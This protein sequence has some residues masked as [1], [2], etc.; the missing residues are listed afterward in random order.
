MQKR[1]L[2]SRTRS[3]VDNSDAMSEAMSDASD[4]SDLSDAS[5]FRDRVMSTA[6]VAVARWLLDLLWLCLDLARRSPPA[7]VAPRP[8]SLA[9]CPSSPRPPSLVVRPPSPE[10]L[11]P[12]RPLLHS[13]PLTCASA[14]NVRAAPT[15]GV[16]RRP[17]RARCLAPP[18]ACT[19]LRGGTELRE[20]MLHIGLQ[21]VAALMVYCWWSRLSVASLLYGLFA[22]WILVIKP[23]APRLLQELKH[24]QQGIGPPPRRP[25]PLRGLGLVRAGRV[26]LTL[27]ADAT[28][29][30]RVNAALPLPRRQAVA[31]PSSYTAWVARP[32]ETTQAVS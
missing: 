20:S 26:H 12:P 24:S 1:A 7:P 11:S 4:G 28:H 15:H 27:A 13:F 3:V 17:V 18:R 25:H 5:G 19:V 6:V 9:P 23:Q 22:L 31:P 30:A 21:A 8:S 14:P 16:W 10:P 32:R 29:R 2:S